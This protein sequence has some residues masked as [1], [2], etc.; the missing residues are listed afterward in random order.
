MIRS[1]LCTALL[2][3]SIPALAIDRYEPG[4]ANDP[5][6]RA[7][8][9]LMGDQRYFSASTELLQLLGEKPDRQLSKVYFRRLADATLNFGVEQ[10][11]STIYRELVPEPST[12]LS[13]AR[14]RLKL[15]EFDYQRGKLAEAIAE[16]EAMKPQ[17]PKQATLEWQDLLGRALLG[18]GRYKEAAAVLAELKD[19]GLQRAFTRYNYG[20]ALIKDGRVTQGLTVL[21]KVGQIDADDPDELAVRDKANLALGYYFLRNQQGGSAI[22]VLQRVRS[23]GPLSNRALLGLG[24]AYLAPGGKGQKKSGEEESS[25]SKSLSTIGVLLR[26]GFLGDDVY[27]RAGLQS[28]RLTKASADEEAALKRALVPWV[29][30]ATRDTIDPAVQEVLLAIPFTLDKLGAHLQSEAF[31]QRAIDALTAA[32]K[33]LDLS[34]A[35]VRSGRMISTM[36]RRTQNVESGWDWE[37]K[38]LPD[39][40]ETYYLQRLI[41]ENRF[42]EPLKNYRDALLLKRNLEAWKDRMADAQAGW[43]ARKGPAV[44]TEQLLSLQISKQK[45]A[46][47]VITPGVP[48]APVS[49]RLSETLS[50]A[51][52]A[53]VSATPPLIDSPII[54]LAAQA[55]PSAAYSGVYERMNALKG[56]IDELLPRV[57][58]TAKAQGKLIEKLAL[59]NLADQRRYTEK[60]LIEARF[61]MARVYDRQLKGVSP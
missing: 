10:R 55:P 56:R 41:A 28:F 4:S 45:E 38:D 59:D 43:L 44:S 25:I 60:Y 16:L 30:L 27:K 50:A 48:P 57:D 58:T 9:F 22:G 6:V 46:P 11:A 2:T 31:Y 42:Q 18:Q 51:D 14:A 32:R 29:E 35:Y 20:V 34:A 21:D 1:I 61:A 5:H 17:L 37:L 7:A 23:D 53:T 36:V 49:L 26:P 13:L 33:N 12:A 3:A 39:A 19:A 24:W 52:F 8:E 47:K 54:L 40:Q 15:A